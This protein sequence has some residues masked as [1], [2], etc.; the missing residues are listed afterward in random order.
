[1]STATTQNTDQLYKEL[2]SYI[3]SRADKQS[4]LIHVL[5][6]AQELFGYLP[7]EVQQFVAGK[8]GIPVAK[9]YGVVSFYSYFTM[10]PRGKHP[11]SICMGTAC[12]VKGADK[13]LEE[14]S[15]QL[16]IAVGECTSD[17]KFSIDSVRCLGAC[18]MAPIVT[19]GGKVFANVTPDKVK[20]IL[21]EF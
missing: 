14:F 16:N 6:K 10:I 4:E 8:V 5:H 12:Y 3:N 9:V 1:M 7:V 17:G 21:A 13:V 11:I 2:E 19:V 20:K 15:R 18:G